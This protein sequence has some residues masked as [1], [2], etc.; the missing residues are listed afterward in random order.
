MSHAL[1]AQAFNALPLSDRALHATKASNFFRT[2]SLGELFEQQ[3]DRHE[4]LSFNAPGLFVDTSKCLWDNSILNSFVVEAFSSGFVQRRDAM[5]R[6]EIVNLTE[7]RAA[8]HTALRA[9]PF[10]AHGPHAAEINAALEKLLAFAETVRA[11]DRITDVVNIGIGGSDLGPQMVV[12]ALEHTHSSRKRFHFVSNVDAHDLHATLR[13]L[14]P[15]HT[16]FIV[17]SKTFTTR[18]TLLNAE[19]AREWFL[20]TGASDIDQH[21]VAVTTAV[22]RARDFGISSCFE[23]WDWVGGRYSFWSSVGLSIAIAI[24]EAGFRSMLRGAWDMDRHFLST[25][26]PHNVPFILGALDIWNRCFL[27]FPTRC[28]SP[29][30]HGLRRLPAYLQQLEMESNGKSV[31]V[32]G[33]RLYCPSAPVIWGEAGTN[34]QHSYFQMLHQGTDI[35]PV[36]FI[37][38]REPGH[39]DAAMHRVLL[40]NAIAQGQALML[41]KPAA[42]AAK[43]SPPTASPLMP[44]HVIAQHRSFS[45]NRPSVSCILDRLDAWHLG[46]LIA[47]QEHRVF[48]SAALLEINPFDQ[49]GVELGKALALDIETRM[50]TGSLDGLDPSTAML[51]RRLTETPSN[52]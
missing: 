6:G 28:V 17:C 2:V 37:V 15:E 47:C 44:K 36:E 51:I 34:G 20:G 29:Y 45:G 13:H 3:P 19:L 50:Q 38:V 21:F 41:G 9:A 16:L 43:E 40:A 22:D 12:Q 1:P 30:H 14:S 49:W 32:S 46:A 33:N 10:D 7:N 52:K 48:T 35:I 23:F 42:E 11:D 31:T 24:G 8:L 26:L 18:E 25:E 27:Q 39:G 5:L 4:S